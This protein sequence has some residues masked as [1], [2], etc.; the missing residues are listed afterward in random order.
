MARR[1]T[2]IGSGCRRIASNTSSSV[3]R[4]IAG[5]LWSNW[6]VTT[7][8]PS[9]TPQETGTRG[10]TAA[11]AQFRF[12]GGSM[13][14]PETLLRS[15]IAAATLYLS[16]PAIAE[17]SPEPSPVTS[18][19]RVPDSPPL[20]PTV[21]VFARYDRLADPYHSGFVDLA[22]PAGGLELTIR[23]LGD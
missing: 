13:R 7:C 14:Y 12:N 8:L 16:H 22:Q 15:L 19:R 20:R 3:A 9:D 11:A 4:R 23:P 21:D 6:L 10:C 18:P 5:R 2:S 17:E 1:C